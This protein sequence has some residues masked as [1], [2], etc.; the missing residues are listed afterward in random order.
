MYTRMSVIVDG[1]IVD[2]LELTDILRNASRSS[3]ISRACSSV[4]HDV[5]LPLARQVVNL[6][7]RVK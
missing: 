7:G 3:P 5:L 1:G 6:M 4:F 2:E